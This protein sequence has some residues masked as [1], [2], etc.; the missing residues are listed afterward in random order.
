MN[1]GSLTAVL[2]P[3][4]RS[5]MSS[6]I[7]LFVIWGGYARLSAD[8]GPRTPS[9]K[10]IVTLDCAQDTEIESKITTCFKQCGLGALF[11]SVEVAFCDIPPEENIYV[12]IG[13]QPPARIPKLG[14]K[15]GPN[16]QF[17][18]SILDHC[19]DESV[20][21]LN[22]VD[23]F[24]AS[25][26]WL[27]RVTKLVEGNE[28]FWVLGSPYRGY[29]K[30]GPEIVAHINGNA[31][32]GVG[33]D[34]FKDVLMKYWYE[35]LCEA[36]PVNPDLAYDIFLSYAHHEIMN[37][38]TWEKTPRE[39]FRFY[40]TLLCKVRHTDLIHNLAGT[41][42]LSGRARINLGEYLAANPAAVLVHGRYLFPQTL[43]F[44]LAELRL[45]DNLPHRSWL[46]GVT[47]LLWALGESRLAKFL[48]SQIIEPKSARS[49]A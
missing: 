45:Q 13:E 49:Y 28:P 36:V 17:F 3:M 19:A 23:C 47:K 30:L 11:L 9:C 33:T 27:G 34:G 12:R 6:L 14:F 1:G 25:K 22:E 7:G 16:T 48:T 2:V 40:S 35:G 10:L 41:E 4:V 42:E 18:R 26:D 21:L 31:L 39:K 43:E 20:V 46:V 44:V 8:D 32:Y 38:S 5:E 15:S 29:G 37:P 24:P